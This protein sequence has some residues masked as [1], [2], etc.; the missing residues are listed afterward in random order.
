MLTIELKGL[1]NHE[2][3]KNKG[4]IFDLENLMFLHEKKNLGKPP[5]RQDHYS[6]DV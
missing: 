1:K 3:S 2:E 5:L 6:F 4:M